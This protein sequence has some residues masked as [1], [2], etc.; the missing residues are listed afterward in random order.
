MLHSEMQPD[1]T[2]ILFAQQVA[3]N[4]GWLAFEASTR[5]QGMQTTLMYLRTVSLY[6][7]CLD[8]PVD[9]RIHIFVTRYNYL[10]TDLSDA[11]NVARRS[12]CPT[13]TICTSLTNSTTGIFASTATSRRQVCIYDHSQ[14]PTSVQLR[15]DDPDKM[16]SSLAQLHLS[17]THGRTDAVKAARERF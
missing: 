11:G 16:I 3:D 7:L 10:V 15:R 14:L 6:L 13:T 17:R 4:G 12:I 8:G 5:P 1:S 2:S 9:G